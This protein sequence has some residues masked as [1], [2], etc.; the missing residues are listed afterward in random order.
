MHNLTLIKDRCIIE[1]HRHLFSATGEPTAGH[2]RKQG[3]HVRSRRRRTEEDHVNLPGS[4][5][6]EAGGGGH[7]AGGGKHAVLDE[8][9]MMSGRRK[10]R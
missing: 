5:Y 4:G 2:P 6:V 7:K 1:E 10:H 3:V 8:K 9:K